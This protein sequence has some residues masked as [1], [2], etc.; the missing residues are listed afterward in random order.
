MYSVGVCCRSL[1]ECTR[2]VCV[3]AVGGS[4]LGGCVL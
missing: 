1:R 4:V 3:V 2:W